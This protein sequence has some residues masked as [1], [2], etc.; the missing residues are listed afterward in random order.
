MKIDL[1]KLEEFVEL[2]F[3]KRIGEVAD[4]SFVSSDIRLLLL[5]DLKIIITGILDDIRFEE[6][7]M[8]KFLK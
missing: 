1:R 2:K 3:S 4:E 7:Q 6:L 8:K 5:N